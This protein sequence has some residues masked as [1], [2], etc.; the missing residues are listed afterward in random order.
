MIVGMKISR[1]LTI[2]V[3][4]TNFCTDLIPFVLKYSKVTTFTWQK[5]IGVEAVG[6]LCRSY[7]VLKYLFDRKFNVSEQCNIYDDFLNTI[8]SL[9]NGVVE[10]K[11]I[12]ESNIK[13]EDKKYLLDQS[14]VYIEN[15]LPPEF[16]NNFTIKVL[17]DLYS[18]IIEEF[19]KIIKENNISLVDINQEFNDTQNKIRDFISYKVELIKSAMT[20]LMDYTIE[21]SIIEPLLQIYKKF[22]VIYGFSF[23]FAARDAF[24]SDLCKLA[25][26]KNLVITLRMREKNIIISK[27][28]FKLVSDFQCLDSNS[29]ILLLNVMQKLYFFLLNL[30]N[31]KEEYDMDVLIQNLE[32]NIKNCYPNNIKTYKSV[33]SGEKES[34]QPHLILSESEEK[35]IKNE[36]AERNV[37]VNQN[38][39]NFSQEP[40][41]ESDLKEVDKVKNN[42]IAIKNGNV[43]TQEVKNTEEDILDSKVPQKLITDN[44]VR[45]EN[46]LKEEKDI[47]VEKEVKIYKDISEDKFIHKPREAQVVKPEEVIEKPAEGGGI[48]SSLKSKMFI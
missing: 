31:Q 29:W 24:I 23:N 22:I 10:T 27:F 38:I 15:I 43:E 12:I 21:A 40:N 41:Q 5:L 11:T 33:L 1:L 28:L 42:E 17:V 18:N 46:H 13:N 30:N 35:I 26:P 47:K 7:K 6:I 32:N 16:N 19:I 45:E 48:F 9:T 14:N 8:V 44:E 34:T 3:T 25:I 37:I 2:I 20:S 39:D 36:I 4:Q